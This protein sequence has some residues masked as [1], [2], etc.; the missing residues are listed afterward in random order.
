M[1]PL[2]RSSDMLTADMLPAHM[3]PAHILRGDAL[4]SHVVANH[5]VPAGSA[6]ESPTNLSSPPKSKLRR[7][8][9]GDSR[10]ELLEE[11]RALRIQLEHVKSKL[12]SAESRMH[13]MHNTMMSNDALLHKYRS[14]LV[15]MFEYGAQ[16]QVSVRARE[17]SQLK[18][19]HGRCKVDG[20][21]ISNSQQ[22]EQDQE[23]EVWSTYSPSASFDPEQSEHT[24]RIHDRG[25]VIS[26]S[27]AAALTKHR[28]TRAPAWTAMEEQI[29]MKAYDKHGCQWKLYQDSLPGR[30]RRQ[31]QSHGSYLIRQGKLAKKNSRPWQRRK[32]LAAGGAP[33]SMMLREEDD[34]VHAQVETQRAPRSDEE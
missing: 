9:A 10:T 11:N 22:E 33:S 2:E 5:M 18:A 1:S 7:L 26:R 24:R 32:Q 16:P 8:H 21:S 15:H 17:E 3:L 19:T 30:S 6:L 13:K 12:R 25:D 29:F 23:E 4:R 31:I 28:R 20:E 14:K 34:D 27:D